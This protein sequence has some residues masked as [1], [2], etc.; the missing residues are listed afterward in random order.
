MHGKEQNQK[1]ALME[2][3]N[4]SNGDALLA[5]KTLYS[6]LSHDE[7]KTLV[8]ELSNVSIDDKKV[9]DF[10]NELSKKISLLMEKREQ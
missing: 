1:A 7:L 9:N 4:S 8:A 5:A 6:S 2:L 10:T 3:Y